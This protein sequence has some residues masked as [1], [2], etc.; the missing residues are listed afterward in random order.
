MLV[1][2]E[3]SKRYSKSEIQN[4]LEYSDKQFTIAIERQYIKFEGNTMFGLFF[5]QFLR[6]NHKKLEELHGHT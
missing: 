5:F 2:I 6:Q 3:L 1:D 4:L